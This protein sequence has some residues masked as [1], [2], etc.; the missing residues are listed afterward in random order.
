VIYAF[1]TH[2]SFLVTFSEKEQWV[3]RW[4]AVSHCWLAIKHSRVLNTV[5]HSSRIDWRFGSQQVIRLF[6][7]KLW[8]VWASVCV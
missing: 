8:P 2:L 1:W 4:D 3:G 6:N 7:R 5:E